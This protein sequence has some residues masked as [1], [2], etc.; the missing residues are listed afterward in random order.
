MRFTTLS[1]VAGAN[2]ICMRPEKVATTYGPTCTLTECF[3]ELEQEG[4][5][6]KYICGE[7]CCS[8]KM[9]NC[10]QTRTGLETINEPGCEVAVDCG[11][12]PVV[13]CEYDCASGECRA[14]CDDSQDTAPSVDPIYCGAGCE[15]ERRHRHLLFA[16]TPHQPTEM[17]GSRTSEPDPT[18]ESCTA[19]S[20]GCPM[21][22]CA[23]KEGCVSVV[24]APLYVGKDGRCCP[25]LCAQECPGVA[26]GISCP[27]GCMPNA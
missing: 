12:H 25:K 11:D 16:T 26:D 4:D 17:D 2:A 5:T 14:V 20:D 10:A 15:P 6:C 24:P 13:G 19:A 18:M 3:A 22:K 9:T 7:T 23:V 21:A 1:L 27:S 8:N